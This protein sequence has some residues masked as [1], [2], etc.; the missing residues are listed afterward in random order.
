MIHSSIFTYFPPISI[1]PNYSF[2]GFSKYGKED[3]ITQ[4]SWKTIG[5]T[6][7]EKVFNMVRK[8][9]NM[10][11]CCLSSIM[12]AWDKGEVGV[13]LKKLP[14]SVQ[15]SPSQDP[16]ELRQ[17]KINE[18]AVK[19]LC[20]MSVESGVEKKHILQQ[21]QQATKDGY[22]PAKSYYDLQSTILKS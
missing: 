16:K 7:E 13:I 12:F 8:E 5:C 6:V 18:F 19:L 2:L 21:V 3:Q 9:F 1:R 22:L 10:C 15:N 20:E 17:R 11:T 14:K 4:E